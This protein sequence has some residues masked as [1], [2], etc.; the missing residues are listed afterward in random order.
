MTFEQEMNRERRIIFTVIIILFVILFM[1]IHACMVEDAKLQQACLISG[2]KWQVVG[3]SS[4]TNYIDSSNGQMG[5]SPVNP[6][7]GTSVMVP[8]ETQYDEYGCVG[9]SK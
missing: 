5:A 9:G 7:G 1:F 2:G 6:S 8:V 3:H 4:V